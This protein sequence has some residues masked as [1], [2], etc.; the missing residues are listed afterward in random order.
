MMNGVR[1]NDVH[2]R[3]DSI[4][5][6]RDLLCGGKRIAIG[7][8]FISQAFCGVVAGEGEKERGE[9]AGGGRAGGRERGW[10]SEGTGQ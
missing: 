8:C 3:A 10:E 9:V 7:P 2:M 4:D 5:P 6:T 1:Q